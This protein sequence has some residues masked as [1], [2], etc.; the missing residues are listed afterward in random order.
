MAEDAQ[1]ED[2]IALHHADFILIDVEVVLFVVGTAFFDTAVEGVVMVGG[3]DAVAGK[4]GQAVEGVIGVLGGV[5]GD[6]VASFVV[7]IGF[8]AGFE[9]LIEVV[10][11]VFFL[12]V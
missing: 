10:E 4:G 2:V 3:G 7:G 5:V 1:L 8:V 11:G 6:E 12:V 9:K